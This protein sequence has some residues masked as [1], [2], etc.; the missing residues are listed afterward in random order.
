MVPRDVNEILETPSAQ[1]K[2]ELILGDASEAR[3]QSQ[4]APPARGCKAMVPRD[5]NEAR[6]SEAG[7][8]LTHMH[9]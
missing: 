5:A 2:Q 9:P 3:D 8:E 6:E 7:S 4:A 1:Q